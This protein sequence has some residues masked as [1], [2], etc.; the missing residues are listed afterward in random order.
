MLDIYNSI[1]ISTV[2]EFMSNYNIF[3]RNK[4]IFS[5]LLLPCVG[6]HDYTQGLLSPYFCL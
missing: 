2:L 5:S 3:E 6:A 4:V 1:S